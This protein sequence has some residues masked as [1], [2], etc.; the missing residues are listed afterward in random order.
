M[1]WWASSSAARESRCSTAT[2]ISP[3]SRQRA[4]A[5]GRAPADFSIGQQR[6]RQVDQDEA[7]EAEQRPEHEDRA[8]HDRVDVHVG[9]EA[10]AD[11]ED[12]AV[13]LVEAELVRGP[14]GG[15]AIE[16]VHAMI[17][18]TECT[19]APVASVL[20]R[21]NTVIAKALTAAIAW[22][23]KYEKDICLP[24]C[25]SAACPPMP[26]VLQGACQTADM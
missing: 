15:G 1:R 24:L 25:L 23:A 26:G 18:A 11:A 7:A 9:G 3:L 20:A 22:R 5:S 4:A 6:D 12:L 2:P 13:G 16:P 8:H 19:C 10:R 17:P 14:A 21:R